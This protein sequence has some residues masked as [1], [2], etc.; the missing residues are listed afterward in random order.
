MEPTPST[1]APSTSFTSEAMTLRLQGSS[2]GYT[3]IDAPAVAGSNT[4]VLPT[5]NGTADQA[6]V[7]NGSGALSWSDRGRLTLGT[8]T[9]LS[10]TSTDITGIPSWVKLIRITILTMSTNGTAVPQLQ[11]GSGSFSTSGYGSQAW[12]AS[13]GS[14]VATTGIYLQSTNAATFVA[15]GALTL[16][17]VGSNQWVADG[18]VALTNATSVGYH[19]AG[20]T[21]ALSGALDRIRFTTVGGTDTF[22]AGFVNLIYQG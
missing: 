16:Q 11:V 7:T 18:T 12:A 19:F 3:E 9:S 22:D 14:G 8:S 2:F 5:G 10:G 13:T 6:L 1:A 17:L 21:P 15:T 4:L 20:Y